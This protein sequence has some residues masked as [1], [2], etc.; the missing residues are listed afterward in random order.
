MGFAVSPYEFA[1]HILAAR[2]TEMWRLLALAFV[3]GCLST[4]ALAQVNA[5]PAE[6]QRYGYQ[7]PYSYLP[8]AYAYYP[9]AYGYDAPYVYYRPYFATPWFDPYDRPYFATPWLPC[10]C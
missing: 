5:D 7:G 6:G 10:P 3:I 8:P 2:E 9:P 1:H 4:P